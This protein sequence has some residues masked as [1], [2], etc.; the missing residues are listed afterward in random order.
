[1]LKENH[2]GTR[3]NIEYYIETHHLFKSIVLRL[4]R[5][6][7]PTIIRIFNQCHL[8]V[9]KIDRQDIC[10]SEILKMVYESNKINNV[11]KHLNLVNN[12]TI[13]SLNS[14][15]YFNYFV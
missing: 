9:E 8:V 11:S 14:A 4:I 1:M 6:S 12:I 2:E 15:K 13:K 7:I 10:D 3:W 5:I